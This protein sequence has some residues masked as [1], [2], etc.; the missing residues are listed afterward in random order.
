MI[1]ATL[2]FSYCCACVPTWSPRSTRAS[3]PR[4]PGSWPDQRRRRQVVRGQPGRPVPRRDRRPAA[5][6]RRPGPGP[7]RHRGTGRSLL[8]PAM[9]RQVLDG[10]PVR[11]EMR[12][13]P[14]RTRYRVLG[15]RRTPRTV[16]A[17][18]A[19]LTEVDKSVE[20]LR[21]LL[22][23]AGPIALV[24]AGGGGWLLA[25]AALRPVDRMAEQ[26]GAIGANRLHD[27]VSVPD[28]ADELARLAVTLNGMLDRIEHGVAEQR[29]FVADASHELRTPLAVM[30]AELEV[31]LG[32]DDPAAGGFR[33]A[34]QRGRGG[35]QDEQD[36]RRP[37]HPGPPRR[38][39]AGAA[40][41]AFRPGRGRRQGRHPAPPARREGGYPA[42]GGCL[43]GAGRGRPHPHHPGGHQP[44]RQ[45]GRVRR[46]WAPRSRSGSGTPPTG[47]GWP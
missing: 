14:D 31:A 38:E 39:P 5:A 15:L 27:R 29:R 17:V 28:A 13:G 25:R 18:A 32:A 46:P 40:P 10:H 11:A 42:H 36:R 41:G 35:G 30:R 7:G 22:L 20:R 3:T 34:G 8:T 1:L 12:P 23:V 47:P 43:V 2:A 26:A 6:L 21:L 4:R 33:G 19:P 37:A 45:R 24:L 9:V 16:L 44:G